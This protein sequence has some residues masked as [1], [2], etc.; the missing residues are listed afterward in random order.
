MDAVHARDAAA[1]EH[2]RVLD[3][4][5]AELAVGADRRVRPD[6]RVD[7]VCPRADDRRSADLRV[8]QDR[9]D[10]DDDPAF[11]VRVVVDLAVD[12]FL[13]R[14]EHETVAVEQRVL[15][16]GVDPPT[17]EDLVVD[18]WPWSTSHW[19]ASVISSSLRADGSIA[20]TASCTRLS[21]R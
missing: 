11:D 20:R 17:F 14:V 15:L 6:V 8:L 16:A 21:K 12:P 10:F 4:G 5:V 9:A 1:F 18:E 19:I 2:D 3:I 7:Q 13:R